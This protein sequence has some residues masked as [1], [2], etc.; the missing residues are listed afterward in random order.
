MLETEVEF[1]KETQKR[2]FSLFDKI[3][4]EIIDL[5]KGQSTLDALTVQG[6][7]NESKLENL[8]IQIRK[9]EGELQALS[10]SGQN[11]QQPSGS[12]QPSTRQVS[13]EPTREN[14]IRMAVE[15]HAR[16]LQPK[17]HNGSTC[18]QHHSDPNRQGPEGG[19]ANQPAISQQQAPSPQELESLRQIL[20]TQSQ[21]SGPPN[22]QG[23][24][25]GDTASFVTTSAVPVEAP[26]HVGPTTGERAVMGMYC[27]GLTP[28]K[29]MVHAFAKV[30]DYRTHRLQNTSAVVTPKQREKL[31]KAKKSLDNTTRSLSFDGENPIDL[32]WF[33]RRLT[34][35]LDSASVSEGEAAL[36]LPWHLTSTPLNVVE[37]QQE[38]ARRQTVP[39]AATWPYLVHALITRFLDDSTLREAYDAVASTSQKEGEDEDTFCDRLQKA[40]SACHNV[41]SDEEV[42]QYFVQGLLPVIRG[43]VSDRLREQSDID[44]RDIAV[45]RR[46]AVTEGRTHRLR[47]QEFTAKAKAATRVIRTRSTAEKTTPVMTVGSQPS[48]GSSGYTTPSNLGADH[49]QFSGMST[50]VPPSRFVPFRVNPGYTYTDIINHMKGGGTESPPDLNLG[51]PADVVKELFPVLAVA[52]ITSPLTSTTTSGTTTPSNVEELMQSLSSKAL[53]GR[54]I[55]R[56][57]NPVPAITPEQLQKALSV[58]P[59]DYWSLNCW[60]C[61]E[62]GHTTFTCPFLTWAQRLYFAYRYY[63]HQIEAN[64]TMAN[65]LAQ[66]E[67]ARE[68]GQD[69]P[70][71]PRSPGRSGGQVRFDGGRAQDNKPWLRPNSPGRTRQPKRV[72]FIQKTEP[73]QQPSESTS[74]S[75]SS[76]TDSEEKE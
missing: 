53:E 41:F 38:E 71:R 24:Q 47:L 1:S 59:T 20:E 73:S 18:C 49:H 54:P 17:Q 23:Q 4:E 40:A 2:I 43:P 69:L 11:I 72:N 39:Y 36:M 58:I 7:T 6:A 67:Q 32:L 9:M 45:A 19:R 16:S 15:D 60:T 5:Q 8:L 42:V 3:E 29:T 37:Q 22:H 46:L 44:Q 12:G 28:H 10:S 35:S 14:L 75:G 25:G 26:V 21:I 63:L 34:R 55:N 51:N 70:Q 13:E 50:L 61:R 56:G 65:Y 57:V 64:P 48:S 31:G 62:G 66:R 52:G 30:V 76:S 27:P 33:L 68:Q 74:S